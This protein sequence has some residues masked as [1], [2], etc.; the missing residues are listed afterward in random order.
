MQL[1]P[2]LAW[3]YQEAVVAIVVAV[4]VVVLEGAVGSHSRGKKSSSSWLFYGA[5]E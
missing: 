3:S 5:G 1:C 4:T 2:L